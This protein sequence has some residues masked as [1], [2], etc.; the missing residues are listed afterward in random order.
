MKYIPYGKQNIS[1][2]DIEAVVSALNSDFLTQGPAIPIF[3]SAVANYSGAQFG[4][5]VSSAT[6]A[7]HLSCLALGLKPGERVWTSPITFVASA[8]CAL[9]CNAKVDFVDIDNRTLNIS[10][11]ELEKKLKEAA[12]RNEIPKIVIPVHFTGKS[13]DM[14]SISELS[15]EYGFKILEDAS[16]ALGGSYEDSKIGSCK[17]SDIMVTSFHP[18]KIVTTGEGGIILTR[19]AKIANS[20]R[21]LRSHGIT[22]N[23]EQ[24][25]NTECGSWYYEQ[26]E[27][28][29]NYRI[30]DIQAAL[31]ISQM[32]RIDSFVSKRRLLAQR[33][34]DCFSKLNIPIGLPEKSDNSA[35]HLYPIRVDSSK[36]HQIFDGLR[37]MNIGVNVH[38]IP[39]HLQP[40]YSKFGFKVGQF[41]AAESFYSEAISLPLYPGLTHAEQNYI[42]STLQSLI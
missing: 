26:Q 42:V 37:K 27:L 7:L 11:V 39:V 40:Y 21:L 19:S 12:Y 4:V 24:F 32:K 6:A 1:T 9:Y 33:Y 2:E 41:P 18:V 30:T 17:Y 14:Q 10:V 36:R 35:W 5:A 23:P 25:Y 31:G 8:N 29:F 15:K 28:G 34:N 13:C 22:R 3:E 20:V 38:Y 16:H